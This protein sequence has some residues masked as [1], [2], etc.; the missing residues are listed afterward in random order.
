[1]DRKSVIVLFICGLLFALWMVLTPRLYPPLP[2]GNPTNTVAAVTNAVTPATEAST[3]PVASPV[4]TGTNQVASLIPAPGAPE[5]TLLMTNGATRYTFTSQG[6]GLKLVEFDEKKYPESVARSSQKLGTNRPAALNRYSPQPILALMNA[7]AIQ[8]DG[9]YKLSRGTRTAPPPTNAPSGAPRLVEFVRAE[10]LMANQVRL[11]KEFELDTNYLLNARFRVENGS[12]QALAIPALEWSVGTAGPESPQDKGDLV[13]FAWHDGKSAKPFTASWF[14]NKSLGCLPGTPRTAY[15]ATTGGAAVHV[16]WA[17]IYSQF[18]FAALMTKEP[19]N[20]LVG[21]RFYLPMPSEEE[22]MAN[23][24]IITNQSAY[25]VTMT[26]PG[27]NVAA[28]GVVQRDFTIFAGPKEYR[29]LEWLGAT[30]NND[31]DSV[32]G[33][34]GIFGIFSR[35]LL[36]AMNALHGLG[37]GYAGAIIVIT[38]SLKV[39]F[40][41]LTQA[42]T[43]SMKRMQELAPQMAALKER[44]KDE[45]E[46]L[47]KKTWE[48]YRENKVNP[49]SG[50]LPMIV[51]IPVF[52]GFFTMVRSAIE[53][54]GAT[55]LWATDLSRPDTVAV[56]SFLNFLPWP[57]TFL[58]NF[59][60]NPLSIIMGIT[61]FFQTRLTPP[62]PGMDP[63]QAKMMRYLPLFF[64]FILYNYSAGLTLYWTV[65]NLLTMAQTKLT[66]TRDKGAADAAK[67]AA[68]VPMRR[69]RQ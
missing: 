24:L 19:G 25:L 41:P 62:S 16:N 32:M 46:K 43:R 21:T 18:F 8:G 37:L 22:Q 63:A 2:P 47:Q 60:V 68:V 23:R 15:R 20:E 17:A 9:A 44:Y 12:T 35:I 14:D 67:P 64:L 45:P 27:T 31:L 51:Q 11:V 69:R 48:F 30:F 66:R 34:G 40:W 50:C 29:V 52:I 61:M 4:G 6:G 42:S 58:H 49:V 38:V 1:M 53:L 59:P 36:L 54:R 28:G 3:P 13:G 26:Q 39:I 56:M 33:Y 55:F 10:K 5:E 57:L 7:Q 65:Q